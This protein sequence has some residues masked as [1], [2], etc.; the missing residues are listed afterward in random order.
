MIF[1]WKL[2]KCVSKNK[3]FVPKK[4]FGPKLWLKTITLLINGRSKADSD[5]QKMKWSTNDTT[6]HFAE[7]ELVKTGYITDQQTS[8][9]RRCELKVIQFDGQ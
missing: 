8:F 1:W 7:V 9:C 4:D 5:F 2:V 3:N 6:G